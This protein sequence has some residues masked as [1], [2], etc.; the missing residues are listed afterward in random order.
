LRKMGSYSVR[1]KR[2]VEKDLRGLPDSQVPR[3]LSAMDKLA[4]DLYPRG[5]IKLSGA[6]TLYRVR[7]G[8]Y[9]IIYEV[10]TQARE[11]TIHY[12]RHRRDAY[13]GL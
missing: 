12:L 5:A 3:V 6:E 13:R 9:R 1:L 2:S 11:V 7:V 8:D 4:S 10:D